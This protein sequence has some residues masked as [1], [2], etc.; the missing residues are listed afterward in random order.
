MR[1]SD[2]SNLH[3]LF[4]LDVRNICDTGITLRAERIDIHPVLPFDDNL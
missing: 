3:W 4:F 2:Y 1:A